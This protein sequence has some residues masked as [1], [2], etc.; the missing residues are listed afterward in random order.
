[1]NGLIYLIGLIVV[2]LFILSFSASAECCPS[3]KGNPVVST[4]RTEIVAVETA[5]LFLQWTPVIAGAFVA[6]A[7]SLILIA[8]G[9]RSASRSP[10]P[11]RVGEMHRRRWQWVPEFIC[12]WLRL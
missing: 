10:L 3:R 12:C 11:R 1:M 8:F 9:W 2:V 6:A 4:E 5:T 7:V